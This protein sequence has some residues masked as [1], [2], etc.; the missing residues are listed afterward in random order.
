MAICPLGNS[1]LYPW[2]IMGSA[3]CSSD[4]LSS[5]SPSWNGSD[6]YATNVT[7]VCSLPK[8]WMLFCK[9]LKVLKLSTFRSVTIKKKVDGNKGICWYDRWNQTILRN[10][11]FL[12][13]DYLYKKYIATNWRKKKMGNK[14]L[15]QPAQ[16]LCWNRRNRKNVTTWYELYYKGRRHKRTKL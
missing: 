16:D 10:V 1:N 8:G 12:S 15:F 5:H 11:P 6:S 3:L 13:I 4:G 7:F 2:E 14:S 9:I